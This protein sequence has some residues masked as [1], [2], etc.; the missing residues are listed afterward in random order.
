[1][2]TVVNPSAKR[3]I[4]TSGWIYGLVF[5]LIAIGIGYVVLAVQPGGSASASSRNPLSEAALSFIQ[6]TLR[7]SAASPA[8]APLALAAAFLLGCLHAL[9]PGH[10][11]TLTGSYLVG[12]RA[13]LR[14]AVLIGTATAFSHT[15]SA[16]VIGVLALSTA[17]QIAS[18]QFFRWIGLPSGFLTVCFGVWLLRRY[19][20][21]RGANIDAHDHTHTHAHSHDD[22]HSHDQ[23]QARDHD[24]P[25][26]DRV[27][28]GGLVAL[29]LMHGIVPTLDALA[30]LLIALNVQQAG[31]GIGLV[32]AYSLGIA[33]VLIAV[34]ALFVRT[35]RLLLDSPRFELIA[36]RAP[37]FAASVVILLGLSLVIRTLVV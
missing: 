1:M 6:T 21:G 29:G 28:L 15:A 19:F 2:G 34:G 3:G 18:T 33:S 31:L 32:L 30:I 23:N 5:L 8:F 36:R 22:H 9:I 16:I 10:N 26:P 25:A 37:A 4:R 14:H 13:Q 17:G 35:Q 7:T 11:K 27:T 12:A 24:H 20:T